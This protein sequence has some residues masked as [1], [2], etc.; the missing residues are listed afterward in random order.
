MIIVQNVEFPL[1]IV[2]FWPFLIFFVTG[3]RAHCLSSP[4]M[5]G[6][7]VLHLL[8]IVLFVNALVLRA[9]NVSADGQHFLVT[10]QR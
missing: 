8:H 7:A 3:L 5:L 4:S 6:C 2:M 1:P 10:C 9:T